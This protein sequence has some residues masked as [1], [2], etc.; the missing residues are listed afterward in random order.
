MKDN[1]LNVNTAAS[2]MGFSG[3]AGYVSDVEDVLRKRRL[4]DSEAGGADEVPV[5]DFWDKGVVTEFSPPVLQYF[6]SSAQ[7]SN[8]GIGSAVKG[9]V[10]IVIS[11]VAAI[12]L[13]QY[14]NAGESVEITAPPEP[15]APIGREQEELYLPPPSLGLKLAEAPEAPAASKYTKDLQWRLYKMRHYSGPI[16][17]VDSQKTQKALQDFFKVHTEFTGVTGKKA[18]FQAV[19]KIYQKGR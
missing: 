5:V 8:L 11:G 9:V 4:T 13:L 1:S 6:D 19:D 16:D 15:V 17:G 12:F 10:A 3:L 7:R 2:A 18:V 14:F